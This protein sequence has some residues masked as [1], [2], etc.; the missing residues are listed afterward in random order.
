MPAPR[1]FD[2]LAERAVVAFEMHL[3][4]LQPGERL[5]FLALNL[6]SSYPFQNPSIHQHVHS[7]SHCHKRNTTTA[8]AAA[9]TATAAT[10]IQAC[11]VPRYKGKKAEEEEEEARGVEGEREISQNLYPSFKCFTK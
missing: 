6:S 10:K 3:G 8:A 5:S 7:L 2:S 4:R 1:L 11:L 9:T